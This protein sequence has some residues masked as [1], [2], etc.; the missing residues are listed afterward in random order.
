M[1]RCLGTVTVG[2]DP[3]FFSIS[4]RYLST[5]SAISRSFPRFSV[6]NDLAIAVRFPSQGNARRVKVFLFDRYFLK[7]ISLYYLL[8][9]GSLLSAGN[10]ANASLRFRRTLTARVFQYLLKDKTCLFLQD[11]VCI[12]TCFHA[13]ASAGTHPVH[14]LFKSGLERISP[15]ERIASAR[16]AGSCF[17]SGREHRQTHDLNQTDIFFLD[18]IL[19]RAD[20]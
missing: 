11:F 17:S 18:V 6:A 16:S 14:M 1:P 19:L 12:F 4:Y 15:P 7:I 2:M 5:K 8:F 3:R 9:I 20:K 13:H 10:R